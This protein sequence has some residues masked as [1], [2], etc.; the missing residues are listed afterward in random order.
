MF[1]KETRGQEVSSII[2]PLIST[3]RRGRGIME[4]YGTH[5]R[6]ED[7]NLGTALLPP[8]IVPGTMPLSF[9]RYLCIKR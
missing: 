6:G 8:W 4:G 9:P 7:S 3:G 2:E 1:L 5:T